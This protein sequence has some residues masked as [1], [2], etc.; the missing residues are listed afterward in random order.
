MPTLQQRFQF[1]ESTAAH[2]ESR[3]RRIKYATIQYPSLVYISREASPAAD[4]IVYYTSSGA[5][6]MIDYANRATDI[7]LISVSMDQHTVQI[8]HKALAY[9]WSDLEI[10]RAMYTGINLPDQKVRQAFRTA[11]EEK[12]RVFLNGDAAY[13][14]DGILNN[15]NIP[16]QN[17]GGDW[18]AATDETIFNEVNTLIGGAWEATGQVRLCDTL[19]LPVAS[20]VAL[21]RPMGMD[22]NQSVMEYIKKYNPYTSETG[23][24][25]MIK[26]LRQLNT[27]AVG[28]IAGGGRAVAYPR[29][30]DVLRFHVPQ[31]LTF[32]EPQR[33]GMGWVYYGRMTLAGLEIMEPSACRYLDGIAPAPP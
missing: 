32:I 28:G 29:D 31:E 7:P 5:G 12:E 20:Y 11:E 9:D 15:T 23:Q 14:W 8:R 4:T 13:G 1:M 18:G 16:T 25:L 3:V 21:G 22:A 27:A 6:E 33:E 10:E 26:T 24:P 17:S 2:V 30:Q 19:L